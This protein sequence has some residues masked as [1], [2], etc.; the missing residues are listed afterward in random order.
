MNVDVYTFQKTVLRSPITRRF[1]LEWS[2]M[3]SIR[4]RC[5]LGIYAAR[6]HSRYVC[7]D[8]RNKWFQFIYITLYIQ[9]KNITFK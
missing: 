3:L 7:L 5:V 9:N 6:G 1:T 4:V 2:L 8:S